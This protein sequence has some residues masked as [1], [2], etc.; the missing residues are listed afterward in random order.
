MLPDCAFST[1]VRPGR[2]RERFSVIFA[3]EEEG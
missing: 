1:T 3:I 2:W